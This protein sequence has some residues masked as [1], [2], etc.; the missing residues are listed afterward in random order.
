MSLDLNLVRHA[1]SRF[2][3][4]DTL[5]SLAEQ[6]LSTVP[7]DNTDRLKRL[8]L[9][10]KTQALVNHDRILNRRKML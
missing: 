3:W 7:A 10:Y 4:A 6:S 2:D 8:S 9:L 5:F 1:L